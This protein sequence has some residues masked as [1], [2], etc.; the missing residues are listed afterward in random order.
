[1][2]VFVTESGREVPGVTAGE[3][4]DDVPS[5]VLATA[6]DT[7]GVAV[8]ADLTPTR[9]RRLA[10]RRTGFTDDPDRRPAIGV[11]L[12]AID[13]PEWNCGSGSFDRIWYAIPRNTSQE[14]VGVPSTDTNYHR[15]IFIEPWTINV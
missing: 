12:L 15:S 10:S 1:V 6:G 4:R 7:P 13:A 8:A 2:P 9:P 3:M 14:G 11:L 5:G